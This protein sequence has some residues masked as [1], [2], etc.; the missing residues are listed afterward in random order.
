M[1]IEVVCPY[2]GLRNLA[3]VLEP[4]ASGMVLAECR[5]EGEVKGCRQNY[6]VRYRVEGEAMM[7][8]GNPEN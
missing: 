4:R 6:V 2:C 8:E 3:Y 5:P 7:I 1:K